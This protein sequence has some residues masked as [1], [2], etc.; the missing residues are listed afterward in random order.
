M[1]ILG[2]NSI[3]EGQVKGRLHPLAFA[4][5]LMADLAVEG[6]QP[7]LWLP[8]ALVAGIWCYFALLTEPGW[9]LA[10]ACG[11]TAVV[12]A[13]WLRHRTFA[14]LVSAALV[15][16]GL[17]KLRAELVY[18]PLLR[19]FEPMVRVEGN[20]T[21]SAHFSKSQVQLL[22]DV[23][24]ISEVPPDEVPRR[25]RLIAKLAGSPIQ[26]GDR[27]VLVADLEPLTRPE[28]PGGFDLARQLYFQSIGATGRAKE[29]V[30]VDGNDIPL[31]YRVARM[32]HQLRAHIGSRIRGAIDGPLGAFAEAL[33]TGERAA[34]PRAM[35]ESLQS[36][37][38]FHVLSISGLHMTLVAGTVFW[39]V[40]A[41]LALFPHA[42]LRWPIK[43][44]AAVAAI[45][46]GLFYM[47]LADFGAA[48]ERSYIMIAVMFFAMLVDRPAISLHNLALAAII[49]LG[50]QPEEAVAAGFQMSFMAVVGLAAFYGWWSARETERKLPHSKAWRIF[51][52]FTRGVVAAL[53]T[54]L[55][56]GSLSGVVASHHFGRLAPFGTVSNILALPLISFVVMP[57]ALI[58]T[59]LIPLGLEHYPFAALGQG[60][61]AV[62]GIS[63]T[64]ASWR[65]AN[66]A[67][68]AL[69]ASLAIGLCVAAMVFCTC[70]TQWRW[71]AVPIVAASLFVGFPRIESGLLIDSKLRNV[72][73]QTM[74]GA[75][76]PAVKTRGQYAFKNWARRAGISPRLLDAAAL[77]GWTC[78]ENHCQ[79]VIDGKR[80]L[81]LL[82]EN[83]TS[84]ACP[85]ADVVIAQYPLRKR[86]RGKLL[87]LDRFDVWRD[88]AHAVRF[89]G[90]GVDVTSSRLMQGIRPWSYEAR[91][92]RAAAQFV[93]KVSQAGTW[94]EGLS[95]PRTCLSK[96]ADS[97]SSAA[98]GETSK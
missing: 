40:R 97:R 30:S 54:T 15:G 29:I 10:S 39:F 86:C 45:V 24:S 34:I 7:V 82:R 55:I 76:V 70:K 93:R 27:I 57:M 78:V 36:S 44:Y 56:A 16:F 88:G 77:P 21:G 64:V 42:A 26:V 60:L 17:A 95:Q 23:T 80:V 19:A 98:C 89:N 5:R 2:G 51:T 13:M 43:K 32:V 83:E 53:L 62:M 37:G 63:N 90:A 81:L 46:V 94:S 87:T 85:A 1:G 74:D 33:V 52:K 72:A 48:T 3:R 18:T 68:P 66:F 47:V 20:V 96:P 59:L 61:D 92:R 50:F 84:G 69:P 6:N 12:L 11:A 67:L 91:A 22:I 4:G 73:L 25:V 71:A 14:V 58:G 65:G 28:Y 79:A 35:T 49:I 31:R 41:L 75:L 38:L 8:L 9:Q